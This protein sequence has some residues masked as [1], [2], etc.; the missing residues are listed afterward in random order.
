[1]MKKYVLIICVLTAIS[2]EKKETAN[3][4]NIENSI[5]PKKENKIVEIV[6]KKNKDIESIQDVDRPNESK[7]IKSKFDIKLLFG[8]WAS[9]PEGPH[10]DFDLNKKSFY[11]VD[12]DGDGDMPYIINEDSLKVYYNDFVNVGIIKKV[13]KDTL[14]IDWNENGTTNYVKWKE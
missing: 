5:R 7:I 2:C 8:I 12:Y 10:A 6:S 9:D 1:M 4:I 14:K 13:T 3:E 11:V